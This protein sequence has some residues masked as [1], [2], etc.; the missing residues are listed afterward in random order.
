M[1]K[2]GV[3]YL[4]PDLKAFYEKDI[5]EGK[6]SA[7]FA[8]C[9]NLQTHSTL[10]GQLVKFFAHNFKDENLMIGAI[11]KNNK[12]KM[13]KVCQRDFPGNDLEN[14]IIQ[15][16][17][18]DE[19]EHV[20]DVMHRAGQLLATHNPAYL[21]VVY[22]KEPEQNSLCTKFTLEELMPE[23]IKIVFI[24]IGDFYGLDLEIFIENKKGDI[25]DLKDKEFNRCYSKIKS[26]LE[27]D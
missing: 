15:C 5:V 14:L 2:F 12:N 8:L 21:F 3:L 24:N 17:K 22:K 7:L 16:K 11:T 27:I 10:N 25:I 20:F 23:H 6:K 1:N 26:E 18:Y 9:Y 19:S 4:A 13:L